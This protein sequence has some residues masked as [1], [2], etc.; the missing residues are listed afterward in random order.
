VTTEQEKLTYTVERAAELIGISRASA[1]KLV[2]VGQLPALRLG[3]RLVIPKRAL[4][5]F[6]NRAALSTCVAPPQKT[7]VTAMANKYGRLA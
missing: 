7:Q 4:E 3:Y 2:K 1:Y 5:E 6:V